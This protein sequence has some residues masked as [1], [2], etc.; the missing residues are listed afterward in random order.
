MNKLIRKDRLSTLMFAGFM[1]VMSARAANAATLNLSD[2]PLF[3]STGAEPNIMLM[4]DSSGSMTNI[5]PEAPY[6][7]NTVYLSS[8]PTTSSN[9]IAAGSN[10][11]LV[12]VS[13]LPRI[14]VNGSGSYVYGTGSS[15]SPAARRCFLTNSMYTARLES[16]QGNYLGAQ[17]TGNFLNWYFS[18][19]TD[20]TGVVWDAGAINET[21]MVINLFTIL[22]VAIFAL[23]KI[24]RGD[25][26]RV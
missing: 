18:T 20:P 24:A 17:Y 7:P 11:D 1:A 19:A 13:N 14:R 16:P 9:R 2:I 3:L 26:A 22:P 23:A 4:F 25:T 5:L 15:T 12:I 8:C 21:L 6:N 10:I